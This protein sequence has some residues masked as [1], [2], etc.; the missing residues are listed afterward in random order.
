MNKSLI[1]V[2]LLALLTVWLYY[3]MNNAYKNKLKENFDQDQVKILEQQK[4]KEQEEQKRKEKE[5]LDNIELFENKQEMLEDILEKDK[6]TLY[7]KYTGDELKDKTVKLLDNYTDN[8][9]K[10]KEEINKL[11][12]N[13]NKIRLIN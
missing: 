3:N 10:I 9:K 4:I 13:L 2:I 11:L 5:I 1:I 12:Q 8:S 7:S 6:K